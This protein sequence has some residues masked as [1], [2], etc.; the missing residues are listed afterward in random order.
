MHSMEKVSIMHN[1]NEKH[2]KNHINHNE[3]WANCRQKVINARA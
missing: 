1:R 2:E 3:S